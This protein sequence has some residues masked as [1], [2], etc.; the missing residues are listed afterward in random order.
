MQALLNDQ[1]R[2]LAGLTLVALVVSSLACGG[3]G[4]VIGQRRTG[5]TPTVALFSTATPG[6]R[7]SGLLVTPTGQPDDPSK[8]TPTGFG[9]VIGPAATAT[10][11]YA[12][13]SAATATAGATLVGPIFQPSDCPEVAGPPPPPKPATFTQYPEAIGLYLSAGGPPAI[14]EATLRS[15]GAL[16]DIAVVQ[17]DTDLTGDGIKEII[18]DLYDPALYKPGVPSPGQLLVYGCSQKGYRLLFS[19]AYSPSTLLP[20]L[21]RVG[22]MNNDTRAELAYSQT[23]CSGT[24]CSTIMNIMSWNATIGAFKPL[25]D[26]PMNATNAKVVIADLDKDGVLEVS[27]NFDPPGDQ[28]SGPPRKY[29]DIWDW[30]GQNYV[31]ALTQLEAPVYRVH[32][33]HDADYRFG[34]ANWREA[35]RLYDRVRDDANLLPWNVPDEMTT[36]RAYATYKKMLAYVGNKQTRPADDTL[37]T[38]QAEN[39]AGTAG[40]GYAVIGQAFMDNYKQSRGDRKKACAAALTVAGTRPETLAALN[41]YGTSNRTYALP[42]LC[43]FTEK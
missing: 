31:L 28:V 15:W 17:S 40:E 29:T 34:Q 10:A 20:V 8:P 37:A 6:G 16:A 3:L 22:D 35:I 24:Q 7:I 38:L 2:W 21:R 27:I 43:P 9:Q 39:P 41:S 11:A 33:L 30:D 26:I 36:L 1:R 18:F 14:L 4:D 32:A 12:T 25:N 42:D 13:M 5:P 23:T 19:T